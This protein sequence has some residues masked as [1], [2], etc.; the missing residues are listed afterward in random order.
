MQYALTME[1]LLFLL[2]RLKLKGLLRDIQEVLDACARASMTPLE[3]LAYALG[4]EVEGREL[5]RV[6]LGMKI[7]HFPRVCTL[8]GFDFT[9]QPGVS[10]GKIRELA[11]LDW[12]RARSNVLFQ[13]PPG[14]GKTHLAIALGRKAVEAG[15][16]V[17]FVSAAVLMRQLEEADAAGRTEF[18]LAQYMKPKLLIVDE[19]GYL[20]VRPSTASLFFHLVAA[21]YE[22]G[23]ILLTTNRPAGEWGMVLGD[24]TVA[25]AILDRYLHHCDVVTIRGESYR[26]REARRNG[27]LGQGPAR[28]EEMRQPGKDLLP[29]GKPGDP[30]AGPP[31]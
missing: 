5:K 14:V 2:G 19:F 17:S 21:R 18:R 30:E 7:A 10:E 13:G 8:E 12:V 29:G 3:V 16:S 1:A 25:T 24:M 22:T 23:S 26:L 28:Q 4:V 6:E 15:C 31:R 27:V 9:C 20:P 11:N